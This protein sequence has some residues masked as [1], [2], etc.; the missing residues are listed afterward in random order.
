MGWGACNRNDTTSPIETPALHPLFV[1]DSAEKGLD[2]KHTTGATGKLWFPE[3]VCGGVA[4]FDYDNDGDLDVYFVQG[5]RLPVTRSYGE[6][7]DDAV[8]PGNVLFENTGD[9]RFRDVTPRAGVGDIGYGIGVACADYDND[10]YVDLYVTN[11]GSN[12]LYRNHGDGTFADVTARAGVGD[13]RFSTSA[14][15]VDYDTDGDLDLFVV[16]YIG[17][18]PELDRATPCYDRRGR[19]RYC[20]PGSFASPAPDALYRNN[21]DGTFE[22]VSAAAGIGTKSGTGM[23]VV[24]SDLDGDGRVDLYVANDAMP[25]HLWINRGDGGFDEGALIAGCALNRDGQSEGGMGVLAEDYDFDGDT[26]LFMVH[27][28]GETHTYYQNDSGVFEDVSAALGLSVSRPYTGFGTAMLDY[29]HD[30]RLDVFVANGKVGRARNAPAE[31]SPYAEPD[32]LYHQTADGTLENVSAAA[33]PYFQTALVGRG[34]ACGD[35]DNDGD[36]DLVVVNADGPAQLLRNT[37]SKADAALRHWLMVKAV[38]T[39]DNRDAIGTRVTIIENGRRRTREVRAAYG[40]ASSS[41]LRVH[42]GLGSVAQVDD[43]IVHWP[44]GSTEQLGPVDG[45]RLITV[46]QG[47]GLSAGS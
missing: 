4:V 33:G 40:Y 41:D 17:W 35:L 34:A 43:V 45:D 28:N 42:F 11:L 44:D 23:G 5:G 20:P 9:G 22:D 3:S 10:G 47:A 26:D 18:T 38:G 12:V 31:Q 13:A 16:N 32:S 36:L 46:R 21:G 37:C 30:G 15:W 14:A 6:R 29:D 2:F 19:P 7:T 24:A 27:L 25:N 1:E 8:V 39:R